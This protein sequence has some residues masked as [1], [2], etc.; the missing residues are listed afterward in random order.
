MKLLN[1]QI[2]PGVVKEIVDDFGAI[3]ASVCGVFTENDSPD[4]L[5]PI[6]PFFTILHGTFSRP[7]IGEK[8]WVISTTDNPTQLLYFKQ[9]ELTEEIKNVIK[10]T[11]SDQCEILSN[12][13]G[14]NGW[15]QIFFSDGTG[16]M[17]RN[18]KVYINLTDDKM[19]LST[20]AKHRTI[21][22]MDEGIS[23]GTENE[24]KEK[25]VLGDS[26]TKLLDK[27]KLNIDCLAKAAS[28]FPYTA[29]LTPALT[30]MS[31]D[32]SIDIKSILSEHVTLD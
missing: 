25:A 17:I 8:I 21:S 22:I 30:Q 4:M 5:P 1:A 23:L 31:Q 28:D 11:G 12:Y 2:T 24:S 10:E 14:K 3:K 32:L 20:G 18:D 9:P 13:D 7:T 26:L 16:W 15:A 29:C 6:Y 19:I 27:L